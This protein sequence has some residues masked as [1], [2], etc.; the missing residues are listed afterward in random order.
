[1]ELFFNIFILWWPCA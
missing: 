1:M